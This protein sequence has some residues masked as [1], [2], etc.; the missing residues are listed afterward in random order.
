MTIYFYAKSNKGVKGFVKMPSMGFGSYGGGVQTL[1][2]LVVN[3]HNKRKRRNVNK[4]A[5]KR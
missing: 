3:I 1:S 2:A 4:K 5:H